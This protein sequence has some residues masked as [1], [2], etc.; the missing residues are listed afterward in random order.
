MTAVQENDIAS[1]GIEPATRT[2]ARFAAELEFDA[3]PHEVVEAAKTLVLDCLGC[4]LYA[5]GLPWS[6]I[7][8]DYVGAEGA[9]EIAGVWGTDR[10]TSPAL[11]ALAN[12]TAG[13]GFEIDDVD[14]RSGL[15]VS[16]VTVPVVLALA[17]AEGGVRGTEFLAAVLAGVE[18]GVR[19]GIAI[20]P[21]HFLRGYHP[22]GTIGPIAA[23]AAGSRALRLDG[24]RTAHAFGVAASMAGGLMGAQQGGM[25]K[26][27]HAGLAG[28]GGVVAA[29]LAQ[30][31]FTGTDD[32]FDIDF[33]GFCS[34]LEGVPGATERLVALM[35]G[36]GSEWMTPS[37]GY[38]LHASCAA[39]HSTLDVVQDLRAEH[40]LTPDD[41]ASVKVTTSHHTYVHC[42]WPY[43]PG[44]VVNAQMSLRYGV[45]AM[46]AT[47]S[48][49]VDQF[50]EE[51]LAD[52]QL[53]D[54]SRRVDVEADE[55]VDR[56]GS[57]NRHIVRV[58]IVKRDGTVLHGGA[59]H[60]RGSHFAPVGRDEIVAK[61][62]QLTEPLKG[63]DG[64]SILSAVL[65]LDESDTVELA[66]LLRST[67]RS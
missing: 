64:E 16:S 24:A 40:D 27:F 48:A 41:V 66:A 17:E 6:R 4:T 30:R 31:G 63:V 12:G 42:G 38:K 22:Q 23:A 36:V 55:A 57:D 51:R 20:S 33:G 35:P 3:V 62:R 14:H 34:T 58:E 13:H 61:F 45:A 18:I 43:V 52:P 37:V 49:F 67:G 32:V 47:G 65:S 60:R 46:L 2:L 28:Q 44:D 10:A 9:A 7:V 54:L 29:R 25:I 8:Q 56:L 11:A 5:A 26:R 50:T 59:E 15:H 53:L 21:G 1:T 19:V 39:N